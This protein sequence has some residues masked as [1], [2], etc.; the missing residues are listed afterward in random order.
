MR[1]AAALAALL[2]APSLAAEPAAPKGAPHEME[3]F[4]LVLLLRAPTWKQLPDAEAAELQRKHI[5]HLTRMGEEGKA[6]VCGPFGDQAD[7]AYRGACIY[8]VAST[9]EA[10]A[11]AES[12]PV[13]RAG[14]LRIE[15]VTWW[16]GKGHM[17]FPKAPA[18]P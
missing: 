3:T 5:A 10:R 9:A 7:P 6:V 15:A 11:L 8:R 17:A 1:L 4:Q 13:V 16:V 12:D 14:Q 18:R 2:A